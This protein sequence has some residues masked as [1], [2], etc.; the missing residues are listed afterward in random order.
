MKTLPTHP[1]QREPILEVGILDRSESVMVR[2]HGAYRVGVNRRFGP[3]ELSLRCHDGVLHCTGEIDLEAEEL[4]FKPVD[5]AACRFLLEATIGIDFHWQQTETQA[6]RG[7]LRL[8]PSGADRLTVINRVPLETYISSVICSEM[9]A[10]S[11]V[12]ATKA[13]AIISRSWLLAQLDKKKEA[14][15]KGT[16]EKGGGRHFSELSE[17]HP[18]SMRG[19]AKKT[20]DPFFS[21]ICRWTEREAHAAYDVCADDHCQRYQGIGRT[22]SAAVAAA[23]AQ[24]RGRVLLFAGQA[25][26][27]R[28]S[29]CCGGVTEQYQTAWAEESIPYLVALADSPGPAPALP[30]L[31]EEPVLRA[32]LQ[33]PPAAYCNCHDRSILSRVLNDYD[34]KTADFF[35]WRIRLGAD[36]AG[37]LVAD[38]L[39]VD[40]GRLVALEPLERGLSGRLKRL[41]LVGEAGS[42]VIG[43][44]LEIRRALSPNHLYSSA[45]VVDPEGP[46]DRPDAFLLRGAGWGHGVGLCQIGA[47]VMACQGIH[48]ED[49][50]RHYYPGTEVVRCYE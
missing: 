2:L 13:H 10:H 46:T 50:L 5:P 12:E 4:E 17:A 49:I 21:E 26:D 32:F 18:Q 15:K 14:E 33:N 48:C 28:F 43:K 6:F 44:E 16:R 35:R 40:L 8:V 47:A 19:I 31:T 20:P 45:F 37:R 24:T 39:G 34:L 3:G 30:A 11:P 27:A 23:I 42:L 1:Y 7:D 22:D 9:N 29:K 36:Q 41:R 25:C 38:K